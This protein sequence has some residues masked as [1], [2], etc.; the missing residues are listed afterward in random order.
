[1]TVK[2]RKIQE[3]Q[4]EIVVTTEKLAK[5]EEVHN[6][7]ENQELV[8]LVYFP[9][10]GIIINALYKAK[11]KTLGDLLSSNESTIR[12]IRNLTPQSAELILDWM[13]NNNFKFYDQP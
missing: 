1:M 3:E 6:Y 2:Q 4:R 13:K 8:N 7:N 9:C 5:I 12:N 10:T 11:I